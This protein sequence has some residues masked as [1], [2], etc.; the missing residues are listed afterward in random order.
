MNDITKFFDLSFTQHNKLFEGIEHP[1]EVIPKIKTY[2]EEILQPEIKGELIG[3]PDIEGDVQIGE[4][5]IVEHGAMIYGPAI[6]GKNCIIRNGA[7]FRGNV[8]VGDNCVI[9]N[10]TELKNCLIFNG[11]H[12]PHFNYIGDSVIG[13]MVHF[14]AGAIVSNAKI[15]K[16]E[17]RVRTHEREYK[18]GLDKFGAIIGDKTEIGSNCVINPGSVIGQ[19]CLMYPLTSWRGVLQ[20]NL[21]VKLRQQQEVVIKK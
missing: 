4:G 5:T 13:Y 7:Y 12:L 1:W 20:S 14:G 3:E 10:S 2:L 9:G 21:I 16:S 11:A 15:P 17:I 18:T 8:I 19:N 6:I